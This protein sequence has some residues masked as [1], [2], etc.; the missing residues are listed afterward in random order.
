M[1]RPA[2]AAAEAIPNAREPM[3]R[4][5]ALYFVVAVGLVPLIWRF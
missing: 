4:M 1:A 3:P 5:I 2:V